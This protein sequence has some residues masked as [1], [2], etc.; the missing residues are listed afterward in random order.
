MLASI[1]GWGGW[2]GSQEGG[3]PHYSGRGGG[4]PGVEWGRGAVYHPPPTACERWTAMPCCTSIWT[5][6]VRSAILLAAWLPARPESVSNA[7]ADCQVEHNRLGISRDEPL[8]VVQWEGLI[9]VN[10]PA[11][12][13]GITRHD[14]A[15]TALQKCPKLRYYAAIALAFSTIPPRILVA[16]A[17][18]TTPVVWCVCGGVRGARLVHV[19]YIGP[20]GPARGAVRRVVG[21]GA[22]APP[23]EQIIGAPADRSTV[24]ACLERYRRVSAAIF[25]VLGRHTDA[26]EKGSLDEAF[27]DV[28]EPVVTESLCARSY[29]GLGAAPQ[30][31][32]CVAWW[33]V[34]AHAL[35]RVRAGPHA[36]WLEEE[37]EGGGGGGATA[38]A[39]ASGQPTC[40]AVRAAAAGKGRPRVWVLLRR[41]RRR[42]TAQ[43]PGVRCWSRGRVTCTCDDP[44]SGA[45][46]AELSDWG[47]PM[48]MSRGRGLRGVGTAHMAGTAAR[49]TAPPR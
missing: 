18:R 44:F 49:P 6:S 42:H 41:G 30:S 19:E 23:T 16:A 20:E 8:A 26:L 35:A 17:Y 14:R 27:L 37:E 22:P 5:A 24:K 25:K 29:P 32:L 48:C 1:T 39:G 45:A 7:I 3:G 2:L 40:T 47:G 46:A 9:A 12:A 10:Y 34:S 43:L 15:A 33:Q 21:P 4:R 13:A 38:S 36:E 31:L 11:R 28:M